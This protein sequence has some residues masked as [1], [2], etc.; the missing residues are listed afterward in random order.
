M[1]GKLFNKSGDGVGKKPIK[2]SVHRKKVY[3]D[4]V[5][6]IDAAKIELEEVVD[7]LRNPIKYQAVGAKMPRGI[8][9]CGPPGN[10]KTLLAR[11]LATEAGAF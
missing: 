4:D 3:F 8:L 10:G 6:G 1:M 2:D 7:A 9:L 11:A 5:A